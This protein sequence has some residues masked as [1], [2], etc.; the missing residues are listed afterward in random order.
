MPIS[1]FYFK[2]SLCFIIF[3]LLAFLFTQSIKSLLTVM[4]PLLHDVSTKRLFFP[5]RWG[6]SS[7]QA[8]MPTY[9]SI[10]R[11]PQMI[12]VWRATVEW[13]WQG[14]TE[15]LGDKPVPVLLCPPQ[16]LHGMIPSRTRASAVRGRWLTTWAMAQPLPNVLVDESSILPRI[17]EV[18]IRNLGL[19]IGYPD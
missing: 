14:K 12:W 18:P 11:V 13:H 5:W 7:T 6:G 10:L 2:Q 9:V 17:R 19:E 8:W 1:L 3:W 15:E 16:I 4:Q